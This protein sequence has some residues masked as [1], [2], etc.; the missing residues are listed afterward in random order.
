MSSVGFWVAVVCLL[1][2][3][4]V[5]GVAI[6]GRYEEIHIKVFRFLDINLT[7]RYRSNRTK[8]QLCHFLKYK[9]RDVL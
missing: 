2:V 3:L 7:K 8:V 6:L 4:I 1:F 5:I 9:I